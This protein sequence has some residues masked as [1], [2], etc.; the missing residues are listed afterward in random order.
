MSD[1]PKVRVLVIDDSA[2]MRKLIPR[3]LARDP[4]I[5]VVGTAMDG[6]FGLKK[7][8]ELKP[9]VVT[10]DLEMP[11]MDGMETLREIMRTFRLPV[12]VVSA[13]S[14][15]G[16]AAT[17]K[18]LSLGAFDFVPKPFDASQARMEGVAEAL[19]EKVKVAARYGAQK[20]RAALPES[21]KAEKPAKRPQQPPTKVVAIGI[22]TGGPNALQH[23]L[24]Q[25][26]GDFT[27]AILVV[28]HMPEGFTEMFARRL[29]E[30]C[31]IDV[32]EAR[33]GDVL[34]AG[35]ALICPGNRHLRVKRMP[36]G[37]VVVLA[38]DDKV[39]GHRPSVDVLFRSVAQEFGRH[40]IGLLMT[41]MGE[42]GADGLGAVKAAG[43][44]TVAQDEHSC[45]VFGMPKAGI[46]RGHVM[47]VVPL[48]AIPSLL[49][50]HCVRGTA[51][52]SKSVAGVNA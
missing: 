12:V 18:A 27:G 48:D 50:R 35:R 6:N 17:F 23:L 29:N 24:S 1:S 47:R 16:A 10:L 41:G 51:K 37:D 13:H 11:R 3:I 36:L 15:N 52:G 39:N 4:E 46:D 42:D 49:I 21:F 33:S 38:D 7:I 5:E 19:V 25:L 20:S 9:N 31:A 40:S 2:L 8:E 22:S 43:G 14:V 44:L 26:P 30:C 28:Q 45:V 34:L 32:K